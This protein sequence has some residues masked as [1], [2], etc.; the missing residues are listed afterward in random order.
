MMSRGG[1]GGGGNGLLTIDTQ[2]RRGEL[3]SAG[4]ISIEKSQALA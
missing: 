4:L 2:P 3:L 1:T